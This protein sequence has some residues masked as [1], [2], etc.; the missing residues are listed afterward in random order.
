[1]TIPSFLKTALPFEVSQFHLELEGKR[2][3]FVQPADHD[4]VMDS[5]PEEKYQ[6]DK[7]LPYWAE[8]WPSAGPF[9]S[10]VAKQPILPDSAACELGCGLGVVA[11]G[12]SIKDIPVVA[13][14]IAAESCLFAAHN[15]AL[16]QTI[17]RVVCADWRALPFKKQFD[18]VV[19]SDVL[20]E[21]RWIP[22]L[23]EAIDLHMTQKGKAWIADPC[24]RYW[25]KFKTASE[26]RGFHCRVVYAEQLPASNVRIEI[27][28]LTRKNCI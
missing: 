15:I 23:I 8:N 20:Y 7:F 16:Q 27:C 5:V 3:T 11:S 13:V 24:R 18:L 28:E 6:Q 9:F 21:E 26:E 1:M 19:A 4:A 10:F 12:L 14:D 25:Q 17:P 22:I 2:Y